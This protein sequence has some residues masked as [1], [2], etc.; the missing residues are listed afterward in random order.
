MRLAKI[1]F[2]DGWGLGRAGVRG[3]TSCLT[4]QAPRSTSNHPSQ[5][6]DGFAGVTTA[7]LVAFLCDRLTS[8]LHPS[9]HV[10]SIGCDQLR[11]RHLCPEL[12]LLEPSLSSGKS[13]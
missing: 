9:R 5:F 10:D 11:I 1:V 2:L 7:W 8:A 13:A 4:Q 12:E 3:C 6:F